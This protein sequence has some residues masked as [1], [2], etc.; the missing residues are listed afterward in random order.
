MPPQ[1]KAIDFII[2][3][4]LH[5]YLIGATK[6]SQ[7]GIQNILNQL[8]YGCNLN[9]GATA[10]AER[11]NYMTIKANPSTLY[12]NSYMT[13]DRYITEKK[14]VLEM[15]GFEKEPLK[16]AVRYAGPNPPA[17]NLLMHNHQVLINHRQ[18]N[19][20]NVIKKAVRMN[21][22]AA[23]V[24]G[25][26]IFRCIFHDR[27]SNLPNNTVSNDIYFVCDAASEFIA[28]ISESNNLPPDR[29]YHCMFSTSTFGDPAT[30]IIPFSDSI[31]T[32]MQTH[33]IYK[34]THLFNN[35]TSQ[36]KGKCNRFSL[37]PATVKHEG[38]GKNV[39]QGAGA[40]LSGPAAVA[41]YRVDKRITHANYKTTG[42]QFSKL[43][44]HDSTANTSKTEIRKEIANTNSM[45]EKVWRAQGKR[46]GDHEQVA[47]ADWLINNPNEITSATTV[48]R[49]QTG[50]NRPMLN[51]SVYPGG[52]ARN[53]ITL[54]CRSNV[55]YVTPDWPAFCFAAFNNISTIFLARPVKGYIIVQFNHL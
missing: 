27:S 7:T 5:D 14:L 8:A 34:Y 37:L 4:I 54:P 41:Q 6:M 23:S 20:F 33:G 49:I 53:A 3:E 30:M 13:N 40:G 36:N 24:L 19:N 42:T 21:Y 44:F 31:N 28:T 11:D 46:L 26:N 17:G 16:L 51:G 38:P 25:N 18:G 22:Y 45:Y 48:H 35:T 10:L 50:V 29:H 43:F 55:Y 39:A 32:P 1:L 2:C 52:A 9:M 15:F 47:F 12:A